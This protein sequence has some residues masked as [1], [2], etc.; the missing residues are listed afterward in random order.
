[1]VQGGRQAGLPKSSAPAD[2]AAVASDSQP[3]A[4]ARMGASAAPGGR[5]PLA[6]GAIRGGAAS[7]LRPGAPTSRKR[8]LEEE[9]EVER[10]LQGRLAKQLKLRKVR[11]CCVC[12][13]AAVC[14]AVTSRRVLRGGAGLTW[15]AARIRCF[16]GIMMQIRMPAHGA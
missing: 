12:A 9:M 5:A 15:T 1:M 16:P 10:R 14:A 2:A 6:S 11:A 4:R 13:A 3:N 7:A 8:A